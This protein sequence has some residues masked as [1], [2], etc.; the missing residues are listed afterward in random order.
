MLAVAYAS[1]GFVQ[2]GAAVTAGD[3]DGFVHPFAERFE[4][5]LAEVLQVTDDFEGWGVV[6]AV[7]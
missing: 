5:L 6:D 2:Q 1:Y 7:A 4:D 3:G